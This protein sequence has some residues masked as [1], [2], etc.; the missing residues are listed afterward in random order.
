[1][2]NKSEKTTKRQAA[3]PGTLCTAPNLGARVPDYLA[4]LLDDAEAEVIENHLGECND[5]RTTYLMIIGLQ[6]A[7]RR[8]RLGANRSSPLTARDPTTGGDTNDQG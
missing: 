8:K 7:G 4:E 2:N 6:E 3:R 5:C 1:M